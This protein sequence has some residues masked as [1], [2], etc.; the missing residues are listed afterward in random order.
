MIAIL[1]GLGAA[2]AFIAWRGFAS[3]RPRRESND[4]D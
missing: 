2:M 1:A 4:V 3:M